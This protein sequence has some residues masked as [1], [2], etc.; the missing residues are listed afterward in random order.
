MF[1]VVYK[2][3][4]K[5]KKNKPWFHKK[6]KK[7]CVFL[8]GFVKW[9]IHVLVV[10]LW[11]L[12]PCCNALSALL[13]G[14]PV[15]LCCRGVPLP[16][17]CQGEGHT[18]NTGTC[19]LWADGRKNQATENQPHAICNNFFWAMPSGLPSLGG[20]V[21]AVVILAILYL[22]NPSFAACTT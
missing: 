4:L 14:L 20:S 6:N 19:C 16:A 5:K 12:S 18:G 8:R 1:K 7:S 15:C 2:I 11:C 21:M 3:W 9:R 10:F 22:L 13:T 17:F